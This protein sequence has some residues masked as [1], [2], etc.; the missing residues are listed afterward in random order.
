MGVPPRKFFRIPKLHTEVFVNDS[1]SV[2]RGGVNWNCV[3]R[4]A[5]CGVYSAPHRKLGCRLGEVIYITDFAKRK[6]RWFLL[7]LNLRM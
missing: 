2:P 5:S 4:L 6:I 7:R 1:F 3:I